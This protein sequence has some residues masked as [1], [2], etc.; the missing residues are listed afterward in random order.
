[1]KIPVDNPLF[2]LPVS[3]GIIFVVT[4]IILFKFPPKNINALYGYRTRRSMENEE[5]W[6]FSQRFS[7]IELIKLGSLLTLIGV[8]GFVYYPPEII[9]VCI[10]S[11]LLILLVIILIIRVENAIK[12]EFK[13]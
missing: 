9:G 7:A 10:G 12:K 3:C 8:L 2:L 6:K 13:L 4:G 5:Q 11:S 1:M